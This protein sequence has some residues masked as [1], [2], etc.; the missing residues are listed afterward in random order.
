VHGFLC[1]I[2]LVVPEHQRLITDLLSLTPLTAAQ[3][4][5]R[6]QVQQRHREHELLQQQQA[7][8][9]AAARLLMAKQQAVGRFMEVLRDF[10][11]SLVAPVLV[12]PPWHL[13]IRFR[14]CCQ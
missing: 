7:Q 9:V 4:Q 2:N 5:H 14:G 3:R 10:A 6:D 13:T 12:C 1:L 8:Q 11:V